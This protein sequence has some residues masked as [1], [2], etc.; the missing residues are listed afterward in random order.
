MTLLYYL[1]T[2]AKKTLSGNTSI[3]LNSKRFN[4]IAINLTLLITKYFYKI[5]IKIDKI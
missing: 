2:F 4:K 1:K 5:Y 3:V